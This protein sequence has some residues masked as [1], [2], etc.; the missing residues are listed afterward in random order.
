MSLVVARNKP[1][2]REIRKHVHA[3]THTNTTQ[4]TESF[5]PSRCFLLASIT[6]KRLVMRAW[7]MWFPEIENRTQERG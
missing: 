2:Y 7:E 6:E 3:R 1:I 5:F 4:E